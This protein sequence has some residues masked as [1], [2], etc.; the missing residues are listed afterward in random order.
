MILDRLIDQLRLR[1]LTVKPG[2]EP[3][4]LLLAGP[5][6]EKTPEVMAALKAFKPQ[7]LERYGAAPDPT[8]EPRGDEVTDD[9]KAPAPR[10]AGLTAVEPHHCRACNALV[11]AVPDEVTEAFCEGPTCPY[12][13]RTGSTNSRG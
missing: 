2:R 4:Q 1:G 6:E 11:L 8:G 9:P 5:T 13:G 10:E 7:L 12:R 3:G